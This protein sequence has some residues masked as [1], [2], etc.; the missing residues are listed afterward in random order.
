MRQSIPPLARFEESPVRRQLMEVLR[1]VKVGQVISYSRLSAEAGEDV[2]RKARHLLDSA[3]A[4]LRREGI[5][6]DAVT[7]VG[8]KRLDDVGAVAVAEGQSRRSER[9]DRRASE[10]LKI[11]NYENLSDVDRRRWDRVSIIVGARRLFSGKRAEQ[12]ADRLLDR[13]GGLKELKSGVLKLFKN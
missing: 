11:A 3:R 5:L 7:N 12:R 2:Q 6:F 4:A 8:L 1:G 13:G 9:A 10:A